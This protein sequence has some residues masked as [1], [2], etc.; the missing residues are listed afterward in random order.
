MASGR[1][2]NPVKESATGNNRAFKT[3]IYS[4]VV[5]ISHAANKLTE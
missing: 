3:L 1:S 4:Y 2:G 5:G